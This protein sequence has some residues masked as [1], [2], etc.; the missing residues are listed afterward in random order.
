MNET[1]RP[2]NKIQLEATKLVVEDGWSSSTT[3]DEETT[4][5]EEIT[6]DDTLNK[7]DHGSG[8][9]REQ[10]RKKQYL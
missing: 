7:R 5:V 8:P 9:Q 4:T 3:L 6:I 1:K 10:N 2:M